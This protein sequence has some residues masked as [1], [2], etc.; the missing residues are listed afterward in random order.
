MRRKEVSKKRWRI[1]RERG[2]QREDESIKSCVYTQASEGSI[3]KEDNNGKS[4]WTS[5]CVV[6]ICMGLGL[7][8]PALSSLSSKKRKKKKSDLAS[9][10][11]QAR[12]KKN[13][14]PFPIFIIFFFFLHKEGGFLVEGNSVRF[15]DYVPWPSIYDTM[16]LCRLV[17]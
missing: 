13:V 2:K 11:L 17:F 4:H 12:A 7:W 10:I 1:E 9:L 15:R 16:T 3:M 14:F 5:C 8:T 6:Y